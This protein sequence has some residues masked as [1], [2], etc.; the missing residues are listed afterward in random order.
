[1]ASQSSSAARVRKH[2]EEMRAKGYVPKQIWVRNKNDPAFLAECKAASEQ[3]SAWDIAHRE[4]LG[5]WY[6]AADDT[7]WV[8]Q[9]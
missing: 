2:R 5:L 9:E 7:G 1:M 3:I 8:G 6:A 4:E